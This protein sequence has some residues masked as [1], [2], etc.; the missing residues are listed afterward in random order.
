MPLPQT[1][2]A[3]VLR[4]KGFDNLALEDVPLPRPGPYQAL[5]RVDA[6]GICAS[7]VKMIA[8]GNDH[9]LLYGWDLT[10]FPAILGD[11]G[12]VTLMVSGEKL[13]E[14][15][16][17]GT[18]YVVQPAV[19]AAPINHLQRYSNNG[20]GV[21]KIACGY[22]LPGHLAEYMLV[23]EE[24]F[25]AKCLIAIPDQAMPLAHAAIA[26]PI[27]CCVSGQF[28][29]IHLLQ[30]ALTEPR[31]A[32][33][34]L[35]RDGTTLVIGL[36]AM[37]L[38]HV[39]VALAQGVRNLVA[40][41]PMGSRRSRMLTNFSDK[42]KANKCSLTVVHP[43]DLPEQIQKTTDGKGADD[44]IIAVGNPKVIEASVHLLGKGGVA[45][46]F[47]GL[48]HGQEY[49]SLNAN[50]IHYDET[51]ITGSS[52]GTAWDISETLA[53]MSE[54]RIDP[55]Q[56]IAKIGGLE[57]AIEMIK[58][59]KEHRLGGKALLYPHHPVPKAFEVSG[60]SAHDEAA[61]LAGESRS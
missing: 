7:L 36:G 27:S 38:M 22:T 57:H 32:S 54:G 10:Q 3:I 33:S 34:G 58:D 28:H 16:S 53:W 35:K 44:L 19:N 61:L 24:V 40:S 2:R 26:E 42:A 60:W 30:K 50:R 5:V 52:G 48:K 6:A 8:Q 59:V 12:S 45:N 18:R 13:Q 37:G 4:G 15:Y 23:P 56:H 25:A 14:K 9:N 11:E 55:S 41:D 49:V 29:H 51:I 43:D 20:V 1:M 31:R 39:D 21:S 47:G 17:P 46:L